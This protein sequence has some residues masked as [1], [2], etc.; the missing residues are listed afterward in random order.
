MKLLV[1]SDI[2]GSIKYAKKLI[3][4]FERENADQM[5]LLGDILYHGPRNDLPEEYNPKEAFELLG[6]YKEKIWAVRGNCDAEV[7]EMVLGFDLMSD[8]RLFHID[9][10]DIIA[11]HGHIYHPAQ[12]P[13]H[14][15][16]VLF[17]YGHTHVAVAEKQGNDYI[18]N[19][20]S[21]SLPKSDTNSYGILENKK[22]FVKDL[23]GNIIKD[24]EIDFQ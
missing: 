6:E 13:L 5:L 24:I 4:I 20:G 1:A 21:I 8:Y 17:L 2:H 11:S 7:D 22:W 23:E 18:G 12:M 10:L 19:P 3:E 15:S 14:T 16:P 9:D